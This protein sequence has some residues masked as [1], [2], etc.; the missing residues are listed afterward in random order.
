[1]VFDVEFI[2]SV[3]YLTPSP[4]CH[5][6]RRKMVHDLTWLEPLHAMDPFLEFYCCCA[7]TVWHIF[8]W[9]FGGWNY[10]VCGAMHW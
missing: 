2:L 3:C 1:M 6:R 5:A 8:R 7:C 9:S 10:V 4:P